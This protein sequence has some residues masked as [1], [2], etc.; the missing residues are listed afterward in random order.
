VYIFGAEKKKYY[1]IIL[2]I[3]AVTLKYY[4][5]I[6]I[7]IMIGAKF[8]VAARQSLFFFFFFFFFS[9]NFPFRGC[10]SFLFLALRGALRFIFGGVSGVVLAHARRASVAHT[11]ARAALLDAAHVDAVG[12][13][14]EADLPVAHDVVKGVLDLVRAQ[15]AC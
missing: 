1:I 2:K 7:I 6:I 8:K 3:G 11:L 15:Q 5:I 14:D 13:V 9:A 10:F 4:I 12:V